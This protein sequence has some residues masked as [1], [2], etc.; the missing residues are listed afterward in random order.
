MVRRGCGRSESVVDRVDRFPP[1][2]EH[3]QSRH[4]GL[5]RRYFRALGMNSAIAAKC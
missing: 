1:T 5:V 3:A 4:T 2:R